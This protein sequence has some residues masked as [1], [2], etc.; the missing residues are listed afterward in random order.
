[1]RL[2]ALSPA[3]DVRQGFIADI[4]GAVPIDKADHHDAGRIS[5]KKPLLS[6]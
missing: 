1:M 6:T 4:D 5:L 2:Q 3:S